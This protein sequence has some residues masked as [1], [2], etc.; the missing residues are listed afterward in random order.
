[1][2]AFQLP[3]HLRSS[4]QFSALGEQA[5]FNPVQ[6]RHT[7]RNSAAGSCS[8]PLCDRRR[9]VTRVATAIASSA[10]IRTQFSTLAASNNPITA[11]VHTTFRLSPLSVMQRAAKK[12]RLSTPACS[13][14]V[15]PPPLPVPPP[16][17]QQRP[18]VPP[19]HQQQQYH[20]QQQ[21]G[22]RKQKEVPPSVQVR[23]DIQMAA[24]ANNLWA[25][26][27]AYDRSKLE[28]HKLNVDSY[29]SLLYLCS[30]G[31]Q[32]EQLLPGTELLTY[33]GLLPWAVNGTAAALVPMAT[34]QKHPTPLEPGSNSHDASHP[35]PTPPAA[36]D[37]GLSTEMHATARAVHARQIFQDMQAAKVEA[38]EMCYTALARLAA[39]AG[40]PDEAF[41][42]VH[43]MLELGIA[44]RLRSFT[45][46]LAAYAQA[47]D[48]ASAFDVDAAIAAAGL[49]MTEAEYARLLQA[50]EAGA[51]WEQ[52][53]CAAHEWVGRW[54]EG[55]WALGSQT[56]ISLTHYPT[57]G[58][59]GCSPSLFPHK[60]MPSHL[61]MPMQWCS[62]PDGH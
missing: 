45:P 15:F 39:A 37:I 13:A 1:V 16:Q 35:A 52:A 57:M 41:N 62:P 20:K 46:A 54:G 32:W 55:G 17:Q 27:A 31:D 43:G 10:V 38:N 4:L 48:V 49:D 60:H 28:G 42:V 2:L 19:P 22:G 53:R 6:I 12:Q 36:R 51:S 40:D 50:A 58:L 7:T 26:L 61:P 44:P 18:P 59:H 33:E 29:T 21:K 34:T 23:Q 30:G 9:L 24:K 56:I 5:H 47:G 14:G 25:A 3:Q 11:L 8:L